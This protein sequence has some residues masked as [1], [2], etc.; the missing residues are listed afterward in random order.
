MEQ[1]ASKDKEKHLV[2]KHLLKPLLC[3][4]H[5]HNSITCGFTAAQLLKN[6]A[7]NPKSRFVIRTYS[8]PIFTQ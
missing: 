2:L 7:R 6:G 4:V 8:L 5:F 1:Y 3:N